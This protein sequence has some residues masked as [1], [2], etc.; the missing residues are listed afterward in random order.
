[1]EIAFY[2]LGCKVNQTETAAM[3]ALFAAAGHSIVPHTRAADV[4]VVNSCTVTAAGEAKSRRALA[5]ARALNPDV[6][7][8]LTGCFPQAF[9]DKA[10]AGFAQVV[11]GTTG[12]AQI[13]QQVETYL[14]NRQPLTAIAPHTREDTFEE[15]PHGA[16]PGHTRAFIKVQDGCNRRC[17]YCIIPLAR[18]PARSRD[19][20][21]IV[22]QARELIQSGVREVVLAGINLPSYGKDTG[23]HL[24]RLAA[25][26]AALPG[27]RRIRL[28]SLDPDL[29]TDEHIDGFAQNPKLCPHF[30]LSLQSGS[31]AVLRRM[32]RPYTAAQVAA[33]ANKLRA[34]FPGCGLT[35]DVI[36]GFPGETEA[37]FAETLAFVRHMGYLKVHVFP[38]SARPGTA[39]A[40]FAGQLPRTEKTARAVTLTTVCDAARADFIASQHGTRHQVLLETPVKGG[41]TGYTGSY[42]PVLAAAPGARQ[43]DIVAGTL[44]V[45]D[46]ERAKF[47]IT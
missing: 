21:G 44:G 34:A 14:Q 2:T 13:V 32:R 6:V 20:G 41:F 27:I 46:G 39:A 30:H 17:A 22:A 40:S 19:E 10:A 11:T 36:V 29:L 7:T 5:R 33:A 35:T 12:R 4:F 38:F 25:A 23:T 16:A 15:L 26:L 18:G 31:D 28:G 37:E 45:F 8:V 42:I 3:Q 47:N 43:G 1:M 9:P 24:A